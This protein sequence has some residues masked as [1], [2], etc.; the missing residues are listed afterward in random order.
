MQQKDSQMSWTFHTMPLENTE[1]TPDLKKYQ[2]ESTITNVNNI[3]YI[4]ILQN[5]ITFH[6]NIHWVCMNT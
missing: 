1:Y 6:S 4:Q 3:N 2:P 5:D